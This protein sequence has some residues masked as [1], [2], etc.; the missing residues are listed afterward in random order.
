MTVRSRVILSVVLLFFALSST[1]RALDGSEIFTLDLPFG[2]NAAT[3]VWLGHP[4]TP[5][6]TFA[7]LDLPITPPD[8]AASLLVTV[9]FQ[10]KSGGFLRVIWQGEPASAEG[11]N[12]VPDPGEA[13]QSSVLCDNLYEGIGMSNQRSLLVSADA[14]KQPGELVFQC[15][16]STLGISRIKLEWLQSSAGLSSPAITDVLVT[17]ANGK[18][19]LASELT[20]QP[21]A[22]QN[23][24]W[25]DRIVDVPVTDVPL[26]I[27][28]GVDFSVQMDGPPTRARLA[29]KEA[30]LPWGQHL[31]V[32][33]NNQRAGVLLPNA[34]ELGDAGYPD[35]KGSTYVGWR[36]G[37]FYVPSG[38]FTAGNNTLQF[39]AEPDVPPATPPD[40]NAALDPLALKDV[41]LQLDYP[42]GSTATARV[43]P[44]Q[45]DA[46]APATLPAPATNAPSADAAPAGPIVPPAVDTN[47][48][49]PPA[50]PLP[51]AQNPALLSLPANP[52]STSTT[53]NAP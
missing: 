13:A 25:H 19:Q 9:F 27:E 47:S 8:P 50:P 43:T 42:A 22:A 51:D 44:V 16:D 12:G 30:G 24:A 17:P 3:P 31:V 41:G 53:T 15:G 18:T 34:P 2:A 46:P 40:P 49:Q 21:P 28:Q 11:A 5:S 39:S 20:G 35:E 48:N 14:M 26:R 32:W 45:A 4:V 52:S 38:F 1:L 6:T 33:L 7:T 29:L 37:T 36:A 23:A 10:E